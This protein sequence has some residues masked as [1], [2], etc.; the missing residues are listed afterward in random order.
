MPY[1]IHSPPHACPARL[2]TWC[3]TWRLGRCSGREIDGW[4][5]GRT[6]RSDSRMGLVVFD[7][8]RVTSDVRPEYRRAQADRPFGQSHK[9]RASAYQPLPESESE[10][11]RRAHE[12]ASAEREVKR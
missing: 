5:R 2:V 6:R 8:D 1:Q 7:G 4:E 11:G 3:R 9:N 10:R 12:V